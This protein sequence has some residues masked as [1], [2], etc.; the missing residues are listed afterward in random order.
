[1]VPKGGEFKLTLSDG[2][3]VWLNSFS[4]LRYPVNFTGKK[5]EVIL[6]GEAYFDVAGDPEHP[7]V[8]KVNDL[9]ISV[10]GTQFNVNAYTEGYR[11]NRVGGRA[12]KSARK[13]GRD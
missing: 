2:T 1:M 6:A 12:C 5:R 3:K 4:E 11:E 10:L 13:D 8:V 9:D 7:F